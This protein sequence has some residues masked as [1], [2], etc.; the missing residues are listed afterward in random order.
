MMVKTSQKNSR[1][2]MVKITKLE[3]GMKPHHLWLFNESYGTFVSFVLT[4]PKDDKLKV[5]TFLTAVPKYCCSLS[6]WIHRP[7]SS[8]LSAH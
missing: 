7:Q 2:N 4:L 3:N 8:E 6:A 5:C 1:I